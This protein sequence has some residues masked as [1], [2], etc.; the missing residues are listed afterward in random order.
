MIIKMAAATASD[1][2]NPEVASR[3]QLQHIQPKKVKPINVWF[4]RW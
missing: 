1:I 4:F 3:T 2:D